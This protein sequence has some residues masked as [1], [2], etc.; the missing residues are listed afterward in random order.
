MVGPPAE[1]AD[2][3]MWTSGFSTETS[4]IEAGVIKELGLSLTF[5]VGVP[6][7]PAGPRPKGTIRLPIKEV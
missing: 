2:M 5:E 3:G 4:F 1:T 7:E 6:G